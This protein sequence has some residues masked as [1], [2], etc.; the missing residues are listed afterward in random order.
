[1]T[2]VTDR[3]H[4]PDQRPWPA[5]ADIDWWRA[6]EE[7]TDS[8]LDE[9]AET[10]PVDDAPAPS[11]YAQPPRV[12]RVVIEDVPTRPPVTPPPAVLTPAAPVELAPEPSTMDETI[13]LPP[14]AA[15][16]PVPSLAM[17][18]V[19]TVPAPR[20]PPAAP[21]RPSPRPVRKSGRRSARGARSLIA[22]PALLAL[23]V[24]GT[25]VA[26]LSAEPF[27]LAFGHGHSGTATVVEGPARCRA[28]FVAADGSFSTSTV[29]LANT[30]TSGCVVGS[31]VPASMVSGGAARAF[32]ADAVGLRLRWLVGAG[33][34]LL[35]GLLIAWSTGAVRFRGWRWLAAVGASVAA[36]W[37]IAATVLATTY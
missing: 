7:T 23:L 12:A 19:V 18:S 1:M 5:D 33:L 4:G 6:V 9:M 35:L 2:D 31:T 14:V 29:D 30:D 15:P 34:L 8:D 3:E 32:A 37:M 24:T 27:W 17:P 21:A 16:V 28:T 36:P 10:A 26:G 11:P 20:K 22:V 13:Q 25:F